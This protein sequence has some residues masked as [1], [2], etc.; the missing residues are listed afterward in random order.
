MEHEENSEPRQMDGELRV[1]K[2]EDAEQPEVRVAEGVRRIGRPPRKLYR[3]G[4]VVEYSGLSRQ[5]VHNYTVIGLIREASRTVAG[6]RLYDEHVF[7]DLQRIMEMR[8]KNTLQQIRETLE[9][10]RA[11]AGAEGVN[12]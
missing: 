6:H 9:K 4:E 11:L 1:N 2:A 7:N 3:I 10:E 12:R 8:T 5:T